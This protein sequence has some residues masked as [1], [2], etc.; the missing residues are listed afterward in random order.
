MG[1][2]GITS[3][4]TYLDNA[5]LPTFVLSLSTS[6]IVHSRSVLEQYK[7]LIESAESLQMHDKLLREKLPHLSRELEGMWAVDR[8]QLC[9]L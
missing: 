2:D 5:T 1:G 7:S 4:F 6:D 9:N 8:N 3:L